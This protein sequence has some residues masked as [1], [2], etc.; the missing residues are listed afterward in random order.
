MGFGKGAVSAGLAHL[1]GYQFAE[2]IYYMKTELIAGVLY[3]V[4]RVDLPAYLCR[5]C[6]MHR[7]GLQPLP[8]G[9]CGHP[10]YAENNFCCPCYKH[11]RRCLYKLAY[12]EQDI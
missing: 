4:V 10:K 8:R 2:D 6:A 3:D 1:T 9:Y 12:E 5:N 11:G 7:H